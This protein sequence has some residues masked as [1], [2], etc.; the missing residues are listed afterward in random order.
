[1]CATRQPTVQ[2]PLSVHHTFSR[3]PKGVAPNGNYSSIS[4]GTSNEANGDYSCVSGENCRI[5]A[6]SYAW[7]GGEYFSDH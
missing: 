3:I 1:M 7:R 4:G 2:P 6:S 5:A